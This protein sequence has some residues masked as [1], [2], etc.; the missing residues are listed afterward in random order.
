MPSSGKKPACDK[1]SILVPAYNESANIENTL[2]TLGKYLVSQGL[3]Y[4]IVLVDDGSRDNTAQ[5]ASDLEMEKVKVIHYQTNMGKGYALR[6]AFD[7]STG[8]VLALYDA[9]LDYPPEHITRFYRIMRSSGADLVIGSK[10]HPQSQVDYPWKRRAISSMA[11]LITKILF[12]LNVKDTQVGMKVFRRRVLA[13]ILPRALVKRFAF[14]IELLALAQRYGYKIIEAPVQMNF[15]FRTS[16]VNLR[17]IWN[18]GW[19][20]LAIFYRLKILKF[21]DKPLAEREAIL[22]KMRRRYSSRK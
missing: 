20:T 10:R 22:E 12:N 15:N 21:Y 3:N 5:L 1:L 14:D 16:A 6:T 17:A 19:D 18:S 11:Q 8:D 4:E 7:N 2:R 9:G 13:D